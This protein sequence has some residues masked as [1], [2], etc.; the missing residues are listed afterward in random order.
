MIAIEQRLGELGGLHPCLYPEGSLLGP[1]TEQEIQELETVVGATLP[2]D[3]REFLLKYG[4]CRFDD[5][6]RTSERAFF[7]INFFYGKSPGNDNTGCIKNA[8]SVYE[9]RMPRSVVPIAYC[10][11]GEIV[12]GVRGAEREQVYYWDRWNEWNWQQQDK[13]AKG[14]KLT[15]EEE[16]QNMTCLA[17]SFE[18]FIFGLEIEE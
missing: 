9:G 3:Y 16:F 17:P 15:K 12:L 10:D 11:D 1:L 18:K 5:I 8:L 2:A 13:L 7:C 14:D 6:V 4:R